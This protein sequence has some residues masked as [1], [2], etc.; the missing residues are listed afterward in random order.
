ML[1]LLSSASRRLPPLSR[2]ENDRLLKE[3]ET[4]VASRSC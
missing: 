3:D 1:P 4:S 2:R